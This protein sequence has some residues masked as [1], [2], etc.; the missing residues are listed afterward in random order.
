MKLNRDQQ[1]M[2][3]QKSGS[4]KYKFTISYKTDQLIQFFYV[5]MTH[6]FCLEK[7]NN[8]VPRVEVKKFYFFKNIQRKYERSI[9]RNNKTSATCTRLLHFMKNFKE[10]F[11]FK[12]T[13]NVF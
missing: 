5:K 11:Y 12:S 4:T 6:K 1:N 10:N 9:S 3:Q 2:D 13:K 8:K 7:N